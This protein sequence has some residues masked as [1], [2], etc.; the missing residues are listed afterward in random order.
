[1]LSLF[2]GHSCRALLAVHAEPVEA[3]FILC[4]FAF[5]LLPLAFSLLPFA[6]CLYPLSFL[7]EPI[8]IGQPSN[9]LNF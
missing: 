9:H 3:S 2:I 8:A 5:C 6:F 4:P 1:M 7:H